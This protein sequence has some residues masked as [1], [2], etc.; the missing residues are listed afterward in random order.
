MQRRDRQQ[1]GA[2][3]REQREERIEDRVAREREHA[4]ARRQQQ[5]GDDADVPRPRH[6]GC[7]PRRH[8]NQRHRC[9]RGHRARAELVL[10]D[11][12]HG[13]ALKLMKQNRL[14]EERLA[15]VARSEPV[16]GGD[17]L[18]CG[19]RVV[20]FVRIPE[21]RLAQTP[22]KNNVQER[23][24]ENRERDRLE[25]LVGETLACGYEAVRR[26]CS[27]ILRLPD[28]YLGWRGKSLHDIYLMPAAAVT[29][30]PVLIVEDDADLREM[31]AQLLTMEGYAAAAVANGR[32]ALSYL[33][34]GH[35]TPNVILLDLMMPVMDG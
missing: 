20:R 35:D 6:H 14:V 5:A 7:K 13:D 15:V 28:R 32:E 9:Q 19:L 18:A 21:G 31:M 3:E 30:C 27:I 4:G 11:Q 2:T 26:A 16:A 12:Q 17:H 10:P 22:E 29:H 1:R 23:A 24:G 8:A 34:D 33:N 25:D